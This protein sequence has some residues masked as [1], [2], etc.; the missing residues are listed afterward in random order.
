MNVKR[1]D[2]INQS[3]TSYKIHIHCE[4]L[5]ISGLLN[6]LHCMKAWRMVCR[7]FLIHFLETKKISMT[8]D[9]D[10]VHILGSNRFCINCLMDFSRT[11]LLTSKINYHKFLLTSSWKAEMKSQSQSF[12]HLTMLHLGFLFKNDNGR[13]SDVRNIYRMTD[14]PE[15][16]YIIKASPEAV[17]K[18]MSS[19]SSTDSFNIAKSFSRLYY[20]SVGWIFPF[21]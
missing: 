13:K 18:E 2:N 8:K 7:I 9:F 4:D 11:K 10:P 19:R 16:T 15:M 3:P 12:V 20:F 21:L 1:A 17:I 14:Q 5:L 6:W